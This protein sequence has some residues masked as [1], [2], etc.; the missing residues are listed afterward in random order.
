MK[1]LVLS[2]LFLILLTAGRVE[3]S[4][5]RDYALVNYT[6]DNGLSHNLVRCMAQDRRG[7]MWFGTADGLNRF[8]GISFRVYDSEDLRHGLR[9]TSVSALCTDRKGRLW[10]GTEQ[11]VYLYDEERDR[12]EPFRACTEYGV[13]VTGPVTDMI[14]NG[15]GRIWI[16]TAAQGFFIYHPEDGRLEQNSR[17]SDE[18]VDLEQG[19]DWNVFVAV[20]NGSV[21]EFDSAGR[22]RLRISPQ[23]GQN[24]ESRIRSLCYSNDE[25][26]GCFEADGLAR[27]LWTDERTAGWELLRRDLSVREL[28]PLPRGELLI[29]S[30]AGLFIYDTTSGELDEVSDLTV[31]HEP[32]THAVNALFRDCEGGIWVATPYNGITYMPRPLK[33][34]E[35]LELN[36]QGD[37]RP[38]MATCLAEDSAGNLWIATDKHGVLRL[39]KDGQM[40][41]N[42][43]RGGSATF[44][45]D[46]RNVRTL[47]ADKHHL[48]MGTASGGVYSYDLRTGQIRN[49]RNEP[50]VATSLCDNEVEELFRDV[51]G[52]IYAGTPWGFARYWRNRDDFR[53]VNKGGN[54]LWVCNFAQGASGAVWVLSR[55]RGAFLYDETNKTFRYYGFYGAGPV[56][57]VC[58]LVDNRGNTWVGTETG[59]YLLNRER[60]RFEMFDTRD[61]LLRG[62][63]VASLEEGSDGTIW[64]AGNNG[65]FCVD[66][67]GK[68]VVY[69]LTAEDGLTGNQFNKRASLH[70]RNGTLYFSGINGIT[71]FRPEQLQRNG[72]VPPV[73]LTG[74]SIND[75]WVDLDRDAT[76][77]SPLKA[78]LLATRDFRLKHD[79]NSVGFTF[80]ALSYQSSVKNR[81]AYRLTSGRDAGEW[82]YGSTNRAV[83]PNLSPGRYLFEV[84]GSNDDGV[85]S[86]N[87]A[88]IAFVIRP[89]FYRSS[90]ALLG[91]LVLLGVAAWLGVWYIRRKHRLKLAEFA[92][93]QEKINY[94]SKIDFFTHVAHEIRTPLSLI[95]VPLESILKM[96]ENFSPRIRDYLRIMGKNTD[97]LLEMVNQLLD[98]R[99]IEETDYKPILSRCDVSQLVQESCQRFAPA[100]EVGHIRLEQHIE[101][102]VVAL[103]D[104]NAISKIVNNL[105]SNALKY[106]RG[107]CAVTLARGENLFRIRVSDDGPGLVPA[108]MD[109]IFDAFY[110][111]GNSKGGTGIGLPLARMLAV[112]HGGTITCTNDV[113]GGAVFTVEIPLQTGDALLPAADGARSPD[114]GTDHEAARS[115][116]PESGVC[117]VLIVEDND[118]LRAMIAEIVSSRY[119]AVTAIHGR[120]ALDVLA[121]KS[122]DLIVSDIMMPVMDGYELCEYVKSEL[123]YCHIPII[124]LTAKTSLEDKVR[125]LE[126]G[127]DAYIEKPFSSAHLMA[128]IDSLLQN[129]ERIRRALLADAGTA[130]TA[131]LGMNRRDAEFMTRLNELME[132]HLCDETFYVEELAEKMFMSRSNFYRKIKSL[133]GISPND[134][135]KRFRLHKAAE[136]VRSNNYL[137]KEIYEQVGFKS[138]SYFS[139][140]FRE[141][142]G[143]TPKQYRDQHAG[144]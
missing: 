21:A 111:S 50:G 84:R 77:A 39:R 29:G 12:F 32:S 13:V 104:R 51:S 138:S 34:V 113:Q 14:E 100:M 31:R 107:R 121:E 109:R 141:E 119:E 57:N 102:N 123:R 17:F 93:R 90:I 63:A 131:S 67:E 139:A 94:R 143:M 66:P 60:N 101:P 114:D 55:N 6:V 26:W 80:A 74:L 79:Q 112:R 2:L 103:I 53:R 19:S 30:D 82:Q 91:Y 83:F 28:L 62:H 20:R 87:T 125:G 126:H 71:L 117:R 56:K 48:W 40:D 24:G 7:F 76:G 85:W 58:M 115:D 144:K 136:M 3:F 75:R 96:E 1:R 99:K 23:I 65:L 89:P 38:I 64:I 35:H 44:A 120:D 132:E 68:R 52:T 41:R 36:P 46:M 140:C 15:D 45:R 133:L 118:D 59:L 137:I 73:Y 16:G 42:P 25:L 108:D 69:H 8:D 135:M 18:V 129:R 9:S 110:Q 49:Y 43:F 97:N 27:L 81:Y 37:N 116:E 54:D 95:K 92:S 4:F 122:C 10:V 11:G 5:G 128:Q 88:R 134:Y 105:M 142:F 86:E 22:E 106:A 61:S 78:S 124:Q 130:D 47:L 127:A 33:R 98:L 70:A 72:Y